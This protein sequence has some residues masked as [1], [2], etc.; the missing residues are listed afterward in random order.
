M[1]ARWLAT[2]PRVLLLDDP[3]KGIDVEAKADLYAIIDE[4]AAE[5]VAILL[6]SSE[7]EELLSTAHRVLVFG[8]GRIR[9]DL[10]GEALTPTALYRAA[11]EVS[12][13]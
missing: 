2:S 10:A 13:A 7:D 5:G 8:S 4:L 9:A 6:H 1:I 12:A 11:Y 3:T